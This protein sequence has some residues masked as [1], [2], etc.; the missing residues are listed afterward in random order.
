MILLVDTGVFSATLARQP[1]PE[2]AALAPRISG[3]QILLAVQTVA[4][5]RYG[6]LVGGWG[7]AC[8]KRLEDAIASTTIV[9][10]TDALIERVAGLRMAC[11]MIGHPLVDRSNA[12]GLWIAAAAVHVGI[13]LVTADHHFDNV[14]GL[15][16]LE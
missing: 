16:L 12:N 4:E 8:Q 3:N 14:P 13:P 5:L 1:R 6:S 15:E 10:V 11:R 9:P 7:T 2:L